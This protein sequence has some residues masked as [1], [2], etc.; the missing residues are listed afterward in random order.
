VLA[1]VHSFTLVGIDPSLCEVEVDVSK[2]GVERT[3]IV[4][5]AQTAVKES[6][7]RVRRA[8][9]NSGFP[10]PDKSQ[11][12]NLAPADVKKEGPSLD[13]PIAI[14]LLR[15]SNSVQTNRHKD[16]LV[17][18]EL[19]LDG[20]LRKIKGALSLAML[21]RDKKFRGVVLPAENAREA[22]VVEGIEVYPVQTLAQAVAFFNEQLPVEPYQ[23]DG[24]PYLQ[25]QLDG[26][27]DFADV[28]GQ[29][30]VK[31]A[32]TIA[33]AGAH[34]ILMVGPP[35]TG[36]SMLAAR[37]PGILPPL[38]RGESLETTRIYSALGL[39]PDG[40]ALLDRR[41]VRTP[42]HSATAQ[43][44]VGGGSIPRPGEVSLAHH[45]I[46][47]LD[48]L[49][50]FSRYVLET[51]RQ[52]MEAGEVTVA[53]VNG[54]VKFPARFM[55]VAAMNPTA[56]GYT[57]A[58]SGPAKM[59]DK[60]LAKLSGPLLDRI[61]IHVEVPTVPYKELTGKIV[62]TSSTTMR[63]QVARA[64]DVQRKRFGDRI[65][66]ARLDSRQLQQHANLSDSCLL[67]MKQAMD[68]MGLSARAYDKVRRVARTLADLDGSEHITEDHLAEAIQYR[69]LDR[70]F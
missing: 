6:I 56:S 17:A 40:I 61:D 11:L 18:G 52:P 21:A 54:S 68:E 29:E 58:G 8:M 70:R 43:A 57:E 12:I 10:F 37:L 42:H 7:E 25:S 50:E 20:K 47:F 62:G 1:K 31:R 63:E 67:L 64:R 9:I 60:Y 38:T 5:L 34:N 30:A 48:E 46:L 28:R 15:A 59:N 24:Q 16:F 14:G 26:D 23:L 39:L 4:G 2:H 41:P 49:P 45:G 27:L 55:L 13:L 35:G 32:I 69:I 3:T 53:R 33:A 65:V 22:A 66:N 19:A 44:L 51:L 36:K